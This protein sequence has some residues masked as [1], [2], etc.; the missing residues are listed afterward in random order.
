MVSL[1]EGSIEGEGIGFEVDLT[2]E[3]GRFSAAV[4]TIHAAVFP[5]N[6][7]GAGIANVVDDRLNIFA[8]TDGIVRL[9]QRKGNDEISV[10]AN[11][12]YS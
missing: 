4:D 5:L 12:I 8:L 3:G 2:S 1:I 10:T 9:E 11:K 6:R 7:E